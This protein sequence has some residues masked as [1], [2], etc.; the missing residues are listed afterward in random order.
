MAVS[1]TS[2][3]RFYIG[4]VVNTDSIGAMTDENAV[5]FFEA[6]AA[7]DWV[8]LEEVESYGD[9]GD[10]SEVATFASVKDRRMRK[11]KTVRDAGTMTIV[12]G[13]DALD[14][15]QIA[16]EAAEKTDFNYGFKLVYKDARDEFDTDSVEYFGGMVLSRAANIGGGSDVTKR[17]FQLGVNTAVYAV[18]TEALIS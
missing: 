3:A 8:E 15:G 1:T 7:E 18:P 13:R 2:G 4:P 12:V 14:A 6:I 16:M 10:T 11:F 17:T 5:I 9:V